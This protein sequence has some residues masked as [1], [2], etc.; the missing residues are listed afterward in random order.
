MFIFNQKTK[1]LFGDN[2]LAELPG[3]LNEPPPKS[4]MESKSCQKLNKLA[5]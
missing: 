3:E 4:R 1:V 2:A 5:N